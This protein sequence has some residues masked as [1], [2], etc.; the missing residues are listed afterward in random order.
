[1]PFAEDQHA[2]EQLAAQG[3]DEPPVAAARTGGGGDR[4]KLERPLCVRDRSPP[5]NGDG[6]WLTPGKSGGSRPDAVALSLITAGQRDAGVFDTS[7]RACRQLAPE[8]AGK[9][10]VKFGY[11]GDRADSSGVRKELGEPF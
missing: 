2:V 1:M 4:A 7:R 10:P 3:A 9:D 11:P 5:G 8:G 6:Q